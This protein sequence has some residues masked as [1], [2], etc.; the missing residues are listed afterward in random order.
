V[1]D[2]RNLTHT[3]VNFRSAATFVRLR[4][5]IATNKGLARKLEE[6]ERRLDTHGQAIAGLIDAIR[7]L[8]SP[9]EPANKR[10]IGFVQD[11]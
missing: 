11:E 7:Q 1:R 5:M 2:D 6:L 10:K 9:P 4:E 8:M 3:W